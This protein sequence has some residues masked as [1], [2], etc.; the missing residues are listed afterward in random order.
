MH[1]CVLNMNLFSSFALVFEYCA[2]SGIFMPRMAQYSK[3]NAKLLKRLKKKY[4]FMG[5]THESLQ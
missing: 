3:P 5:F 1:S 2:I 4:A